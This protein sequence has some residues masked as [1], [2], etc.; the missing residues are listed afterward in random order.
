MGILPAYTSEHHMP[1][2]CPR[3]QKRVSDPLTLESWMGIV[4]SMWQNL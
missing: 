2:C 1:I 4:V 3:N